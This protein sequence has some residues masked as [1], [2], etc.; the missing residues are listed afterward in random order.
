LRILATENRQEGLDV[1][2][3]ER[4][5]GGEGGGFVADMKS[6]VVEQYIGF[7]ALA[8]EGEGGVKGD[9]APVVVVG[10]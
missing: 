10:V 6:S 7:Y 1:E 9:G 5:F 2:C 3:I 4:A 8:A